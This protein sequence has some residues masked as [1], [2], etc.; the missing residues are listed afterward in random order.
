[1]EKRGSTI[2][3]T[4]LVVIA[5]YFFL[6][7]AVQFNLAATVSLMEEPVTVMVDAGHGGE[8][9]GASTAD[10][11]KESDI[12]LAIALRLEQLLALCG[13]PV[14]MIRRTDTAV[15]SD[16]AGSF[17]EKKTS[18]LRNR[19]A[20]VNAAPRAILVSIHQ[21]HFSQGQYDGAQVFY[22]AASGSEALAKLTQN[23]LR[24]ALD[25]TNDRQIKAGDAIYLL[26]AIEC[27]GILVE[28]GFLSNAAEAK[29]L[30]D[31][32]YQQKIACAISSAV[33]R[34]LE[35]EDQE[36]ENENHILLYSL[37]Q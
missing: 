2:L 21:N 25:R 20:M 6:Y 8:D 4:A 23:T 11:V 22:A 19:A 26:E 34:Y 29:R 13:T 27:P 16:G 32:G 31:P 7:Q 14:D 3:A 17:S 5:A 9:G 30:Q 18:D 15:Y 24:E 36:N 37:R 33:V 12:N 1:M 10:G 28:C 35:S